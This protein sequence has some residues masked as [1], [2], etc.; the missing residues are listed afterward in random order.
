MPD[1]GNWMADFP[2]RLLLCDLTMPGSHDAGINRDDATGVGIGGLKKSTAICQDVDIAL[3]CFRGSR[4]FDIRFEVSSEDIRTY[5][6]APGFG[7]ALGESAEQILEGV[8]QFL[9][10]HPG[11]FVILRITKPKGAKDEIISAILNSSLK[12]R[13]YKSPTFVNFAGQ[14]IGSLRGKAICCFD[15]DLPSQGVVSKVLQK[16]GVGSGPKVPFNMLTPQFG[17]FPFARYV[18]DDQ[19]GVVTCGKYSEASDLRDVIDGQVA[20]M[21]E[22]RQH[23][24]GSHL[25]VLYWTQT[26][27]GSNIRKHTMALP[28][29]GRFT[30]SFGG[31]H[32]NMGQLTGLLTSGRAMNGRRNV[33]VQATTYQDRRAIMP[34][35]IMYDFVNERMSSEIVSLNHPGVRAHLLYEEENPWV[36][37]G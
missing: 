5:H 37:A 11:E 21:D 6:K 1:M 32:H 17:L 15:I 26:F 23:T 35:V 4:F 10:S 9:Q 14:Q 25:F 28:S 27:K 31:A 16:V 3:Q 20:K 34:N 13:M 2:D 36:I 30:T 33:R 18:S 29:T 8:Y 19:F 22:H 24:R 7:G 12:D